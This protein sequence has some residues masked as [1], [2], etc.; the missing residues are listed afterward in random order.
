MTLIKLKKTFSHI[1]KMT[2]K[3]DIFPCKTEI[4]LNSLLKLYANVIYNDV[5]IL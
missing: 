5:E 4:L 3:I 1:S 2:N